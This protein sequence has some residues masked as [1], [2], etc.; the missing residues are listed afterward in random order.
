M[1]MFP[2]WLSPGEKQV[3]LNREGGIY[4]K[5]RRHSI[6]EFPAVTRLRFRLARD[7]SRIKLCYEIYG[8]CENSQRHQESLTRCQRDPTRTANL[9]KI[10][11]ITKPAKICKIS[12][13][14]NENYENYKTAK[15]RKS[16]KN[17]LRDVRGT[18]RELRILQKLRESQKLRQFARSQKDPTRFTRIMKTAKSRKGTKNGL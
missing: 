2:N 16:T 11:G 4:S 13:G 9:T 10:T 1:L 18:Q 7:I 5:S 17:G 8:N 3:R 12:A 15:T 6:P 14:P